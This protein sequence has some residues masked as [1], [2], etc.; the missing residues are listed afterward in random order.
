[1][2]RIS[3]LSEKPLG[4]RPR[5]LAHWLNPTGRKK[6][7]SLVDKVYK[8]KNLEL[9]WEKVKRN[10]GAG[11]VDGQSI[12][13][14]ASNLDG[15][16]ARLHD[17]L[18]SQTYRPQPVKR[19]L[20]PK[21]GQ[22]GKFRPLGIPTVYDRVCQQALLNRL[23]PIFEPV[24]DEASFGYRRGRSAKDALRKIWCEVEQGHEW[25][26]D[27]DLKDFFGSADH[28]K[29]MVL[30]NQ[31]VADGRVLA[32]VESIMK[33]GYLEG[34]KVYQTQRGVPQGGVI[35][36]L[37]S[38]VLLTPFDREM[39]R[40]GYRMTRYADD[41]LVTCSTRAEAQSVL[42]FATRVLEKLGVDLN[43]DKTRIVHVRQGFEFLGYKIKRGKRPL[44]LPS[45]RIKS[46][47]VQGSL[48][49][50]PRQKSID[51][52]KE[53]IR[54]RTCRKAPVTTEQLIEQI[55]PVIRGWG[56][57][58]KKSHV[59]KLFNQLDRWIIRRIWSHRHKRWRNAG[60]KNLPG[61]K[62]YGKLGLVSLIQLIPSLNRRGSAAL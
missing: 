36:P 8:L 39:R 33:V 57:Y 35:S 53:Q 2:A 59:R 50:Y 24:F 34:G 18:C 21:G 55:N 27:A 14:F 40:K 20:I 4:D 43:M 52:F 62:L 45:H 38:N 47:T 32:L 48:Y 56:N 11:G 42:V 25:V 23:E 6:V 15:N 31:Q 17:E 41:W 10:R 44:K 58:Y 49:A 5:R 12:K 16:L 37:I 60:W 54:K 13:D 51:H 9:A 1:M 29:V 46:G 61:S 3:S 26:V 7:H 28:E 22:P 19:Q 30:L